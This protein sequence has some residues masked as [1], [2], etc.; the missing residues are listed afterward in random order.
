[1]CDKQVYQFRL[2]GDKMR[3]RGMSGMLLQW[4]DN[5]KS[6]SSQ[7]PE[8]LDVAGLLIMHKEDRD[9]LLAWVQAKQKLE[10]QK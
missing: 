10:L 5:K 2:K 9:A 7:I 3:P 8:D 6:L 1:M 4:G